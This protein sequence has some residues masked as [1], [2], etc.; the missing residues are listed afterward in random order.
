MDRDRFAR[1]AVVIATFVLAP[2]LLEMLAWYIE[3]ED[4]NV[5][6]AVTVLAVVAA[7]A[8]IAAVAGR[9][10]GRLPVMLVTA[11]TVAAAGGLVLGFAAGF[12]PVLWNRGVPGELLGLSMI[13]IAA[14]TAL[15]GGYLLFLYRRG[16]YVPH[17]ETTAGPSPT[18]TKR[19]VI[20]ES[21]ILI[22]TL[23]EISHALE[24]ALGSCVSVIDQEDLHFVAFF[25]PSGCAFYTDVL[26]D[27]DLQ[28]FFHETTPEE[29]RITYL[30]LGSQ[31]HWIGG[32]LDTHLRSMES[33]T[34][35]RTVLDVERG[36]LFHYWVDHGRYIIGVTLDQR[37]VGVADDKM[38]R[39][40]DMIRGHF[41]LPPI[42]QRVRQQPGAN[43]RPIK[44][45]DAWPESG[46]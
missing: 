3:G 2:V 19:K 23:P 36:A 9:V 1:V 13:G 17:L 38:A 22:R 24:K 43:V 4:Y 45:E 25:G 46:S 37:R 26:D 27:A 6:R 20:G 18:T 35:I 16:L 32:R 34:V 44:K 10:R 41:T 29:R 8:L 30:R 5:S 11:M 40:V 21:E 31:L 28:H 15:T 14:F 39:L 12:G 42:N 33:G 7:L